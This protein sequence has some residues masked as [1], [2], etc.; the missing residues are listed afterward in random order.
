MMNTGDNNS[1]KKKKKKKKKRKKNVLI[2]IKI[3]KIM[4]YTRPKI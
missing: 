1:G 2:G 3:I 4:I